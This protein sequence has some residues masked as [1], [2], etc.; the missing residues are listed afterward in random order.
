L[1]GQSLRRLKQKALIEIKAE[2]ID[3]DQEIRF[4]AFAALQPA[5]IPDHTEQ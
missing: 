4:L 1:I 5:L 2:S 3:R